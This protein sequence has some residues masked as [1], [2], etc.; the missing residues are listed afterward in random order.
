MY[1]VKKYI[2]F[3]LD[4]TVTDSK[5]G[6]IRSVQHALHFLGVKRTDEELLPFIGPP[7]RD[8]FGRLFPDDAETV[9]LAVKKYREY[10]SVTGIFENSLYGGIADLLRDLGQQGRVVCLAT[11]KP[12]PFALRILE[13]FNIAGYF[14]HVAGAE[15]TGPRNSKT[16][17][18]QHACTLCGVD[19]LSRCLMIGD[20]KYDVQ[21]AHAVGMAC[22]GVLYGYGSRN[23]LETAGADCLCADV[24]DLRQRLLESKKC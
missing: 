2:F 5:T 18:L 3:D 13:H 12:E 6:I 15:L 23:E 10:Y 20:R 14:D 19:D 21:G 24:A 16:A 9:D 11:S 1:C 4:G 8:S 17:V 7:L 22:A